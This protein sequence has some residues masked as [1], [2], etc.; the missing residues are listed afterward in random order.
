M[1]LTRRIR[2][3]L[4][5]LGLALGALVL[6]EGGLWVAGVG[7][8]DRRAVGLGF[9]P[10]A[11]YLVPGAS[12][13]GTWR[14]RFH[15]TIRANFDI[16]PHGARP[17]ALLFGASSAS[18]I[19]AGDFGF[20][21]ARGVYGEP[22]EVV[23]LTRNGYGTSRV[24]LIFE[25][26]LRRLS[27]D[28][29]VV[30]SGDNDFVEALPWQRE[31][32]SG[33]ADSAGVLTDIVRRSRVFNSLLTL[34]RGGDAI[35]AGRPEEFVVLTRQQRASMTRED[36]L[37]A[38]E[39]VRENLRRMCEV[40]RE[41]GV[42]LV[43]CT[44]VY[45]HLSMPYDSGNHSELR[46][47]ARGEFLR[48]RRSV[49]AGLPGLVTTLLPPN[50]NLRIHS[51][52]WNAVRKKPTEPWPETLPGRRTCLG[53]LADLEFRHTEPWRWDPRIWEFYGALE[54]FHANDASGS[55][56][57]S[58][59]RAEV[60][61]SALLALDPTHAHTHFVLGLVQYLLERPVF[62]EH[63][64]L[65][66]DLDRIPRR[67][68]RRINDLIREVAAGFPEVL[69]FDA[70]AYFESLMPDGLVGWEWMLDQ[71]HLPPGASQVLRTE[72][73]RA[74]AARWN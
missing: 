9:D 55:V 25:Q 2:G 27:P 36:T 51:R 54:R 8:R 21:L 69:L 18:V 13:P 39:L 62:L 28:L 53:P 45:N 59:E 3:L 42:R 26:A 61:L 73:V 70:A 63:L 50:D 37:A 12:E 20:L 19:G 60:E 6:L 1:D 64:K 57:E 4:P 44:L 31:Q 24:T 41:G 35:D 68:S 49:L 71:A 56:L 11:T 40:A 32:P 72:L 23:N 66:A 47:P 43:L 52:E 34:T 48:A 38:G 29:A 74:I 46:P 58:L 14:T 15:P 17:R 22:V 33:G 65:A 10:D 30:Y 5:G 16:P 7:G 67:S